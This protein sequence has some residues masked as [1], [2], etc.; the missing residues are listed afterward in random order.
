M[1]GLRKFR[2]VVLLTL[3]VIAVL[4]LAACGAPAAAPA[5]APAA[6]EGAAEETAADTADDGGEEVL[7][8][9]YW[10]APSIPNPHLSGGTKDQDVV[11]HHA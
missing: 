2:G 10:Q 11:G 9:L 7:N 4:A 8:I 5:D 6:E 3:L 1:E